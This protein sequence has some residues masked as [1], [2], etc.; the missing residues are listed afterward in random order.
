M[1]KEK[2]MPLIFVEL[3]EDYLGL[4]INQILPILKGFEVTYILRKCL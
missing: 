1:E 4:F 2:E 3:T